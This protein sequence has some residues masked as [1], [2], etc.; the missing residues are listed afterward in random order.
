M[1]LV[2]PSKESLQVFMHNMVQLRDVMK[3]IGLQE[4]AVKAQESYN[5][6][7]QYYLYLKELEESGWMD[8]IGNV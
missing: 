8:E 4:V 1:I 7:C 5:G 2:K 6:A 3:S